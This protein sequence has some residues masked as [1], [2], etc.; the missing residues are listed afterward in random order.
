MEKEINIYMKKILDILQNRN[1]SDYKVCKDL[2]ISKSTFS[3]WRKGSV[4]SVEIYAQIV[5]YLGISSD[6]ILN[7][8]TKQSEITL[9]EDEKEILDYFRKLPDREKMRELGRLEAL[10]MQHSAESGSTTYKTG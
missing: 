10:A 7:I 2:K 8:K 6:E 4:A 5:R 3:S 9:T 1:I